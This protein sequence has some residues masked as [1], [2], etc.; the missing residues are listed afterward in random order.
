MG[1]TGTYIHRAS[2]VLLVC[3]LSSICR[4]ELRAALGFRNTGVTRWVQIVGFALEI[5]RGIAGLANSAVLFSWKINKHAFLCISG[6]LFRIIN[7]VP[8]WLWIFR[9]IGLLP[10]RLIGELGGMVVF[11]LFH[12]AQMVGTGYVNIATT[13]CAV[14]SWMHYI[15]LSCVIGDSRG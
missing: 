5:Y 13:L 11:S 10:L 3:P 15:A 8:M 7:A 4:S 1:K 12:S 2:L 6:G 14:Y 9:G